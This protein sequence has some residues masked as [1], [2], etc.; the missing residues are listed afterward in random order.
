[1][2]GIMLSGTLS[3][4]DKAVP[5]AVTALGKGQLPA[6]LG[7]GPEGHDQC[8]SHLSTTSVMLLLTMKDPSNSNYTN[9]SLA[10]APGHRDPGSDSPA[11]SCF[12]SPC[13]GFQLT[14]LQLITRGEEQGKAILPTAV[15]HWDL[16][17]CIPGEV[18]SHRVVQHLALRYCNL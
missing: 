8:H 2:L 13:T 18:N 11:L 17:G 15:L 5:G 9:P 10:P 4:L 12:P 14:M 1:M 3:A 7:S 16:T 6:L